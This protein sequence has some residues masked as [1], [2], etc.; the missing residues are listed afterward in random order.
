MA[1]TQKVDTRGLSCPQ[2]VMLVYRTI[3]KLKTG[4]VEILADSATARENITRLVRNN[5][6][7]IT[8]ETRADG[9]YLLL[10]RK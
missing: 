5:G 4:T 2:P 10:L 9:S 1:N 3:G 7:E 6:W 8:T